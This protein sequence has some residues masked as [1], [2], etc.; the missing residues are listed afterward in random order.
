[1]KTR[2]PHDVATARRPGRPI[3]AAMGTAGW[4]QAQADRARIRT[5]LRAPPD[6]RAP[7]TTSVPASTT[8]HGA[9][10]APIAG[11]A[12]IVR[13]GGQAL[14]PA[15]PRAGER[16]ETIAKH[17]ISGSRT[18]A[19]PPAP[20]PGVSPPW[21]IQAR[22][23]IGAVD[24]P[25]E[26]QADEMADRVLRMTEPAPATP[27]TLRRER[28]SSA[29]Q[30]HHEQEDSAHSSAAVARKPLPGKP[31]LEGTAAPPLVHEVLGAP[32][33]PLD[34]ATRSFFESRFGHDF[35]QVR[36]HSDDRAAESARSVGARAYTVG[37]HIVFGSGQLQLGDDRGRWLLAHELAHVTQRGPPF[38]AIF[39]APLTYDKTAFPLKPPSPLF[40]LDDAKKEVEDRKSATPSQLKSGAVKGAA[41]GSIEEIF[42][43]HT[44]ARV[45]T[46]DRW[47]SELDLVAP[48]GW[49]PSPN[50]D[51][52]VG[53]ITVDIEADGKGTAELI[54]RDPVAVPTTFTKP[55]DAI[56]HLTTTYRLKAVSDGTAKWDPVELNKIAGAFALLRTSDRSALQGVELV[57]ASTLDGGKA[58]G[59]F[60]SSTSMS[61]TAV[62]SEDKLQIAN[63]AFR[64]EGTKFV[65]GKTVQS[66]ASYQAIV[67]EVG[68][69]VARRALHEAT[70]ADMEA[71]LAQ[72]QAGKALTGAGATTKG[73]ADEYNAILE[74]LKTLESDLA[75]AR[76]SKNQAAIATAQAAVDSK[77][78]DKAAKKK[79]YED[80]NTAQKAA[81]KTYD[82]AK[83]KV[84]EKDKVKKAAKAPIGKYVFAASSKK[85]AATGLLNSAKRSAAGYKTTDQDESAA[86]RDA[87]EGVATAIAKY[88]TDAAAAEGDALN[89]LDSA[90]DPALNA[91]T[92]AR[93]A[94]TTANPANPA[95][96]S[97]QPVESAQDAWLE[98]EM[99][100]AYARFRTMR[101]EK[102]VEF[103]NAN[104]IS[105]FTQYAKETW[106]VK[107]EEFFAEAYS[108]WRTDPDFLKNSHR[109][110]F[111]WFE[112]SGYK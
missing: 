75:A 111:N 53:E 50:I 16:A 95:L 18:S 90:V 36:I 55:E 94:L 6:W 35:T 49:P 24:D 73:F 87:V 89:A 105:P 81:Q 15:Q 76:K 85:T 96:K 29:A 109:D 54:A 48:I 28:S 46:R 112:K 82:T 45:G 26:R 63:C 56:T 4:A 66:P 97:F 19:M 101:V 65:G 25:M 33:H 86:Y 93:E 11:R 13:I 92:K 42:L 99:T 12:N 60:T 68:H 69:A 88:T 1:V 71:A 106:P 110:L 78:K 107:P 52:P 47:G 21:P 34:F 20:Q 51:P 43:W 83:V 37:R 27:A 77:K 74:D 59:M 58:C 40:T 22:L 61:E 2:I 31:S 70:V 8:K 10:G 14:D 67:H 9:G 32:G 84:E 91:R 62:T 23:K 41:S 64:D 72:N 7:A 108:L 79:Q 98:A 57:R 17:G 38:P 104:K 100:L 5:V 39:R 103:V 102:F 30:D 3:P 80:A 44:L